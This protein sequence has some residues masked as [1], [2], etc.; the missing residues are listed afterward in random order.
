MTIIKEQKSGHKVTQF[1]PIVL[2]R[3]AGEM[4]SGIAFHVHAAGYRVC[5]TEVAN[6]LAVSRANSF[7]DAVFDGIKNVCGV[8]AE[9]V[10][11]SIPEIKKVWRKG[12]IALLVDPEAAIKEKLHPD[13]LIDGTMTKIGTSTGKGDARL[14][15]GIGPGFYAG[16]D[17]HIVVETNDS[18]GKAGKLIFDGTADEDTEIPVD[19]GGKTVERVLWAP[20]AGTFTAN[21]QIGD[22]LE[23]GQFIG[24]VDN[25]SLTATI[26]GKLR[27]IIRSGTSVPKGAKL[28][29]IDPVNEPGVFFLIRGK[30]W[31]IGEAVVEA[32]SLYLSK[33]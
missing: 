2:I 4:A 33:K 21:M 29:E 25:M 30:I 22:S 18:K 9:R 15:I 23:P 13:V 8:T 16:R 14:V 1:K 17:V 6:P 32:I 3:G 24:K 28:I 20:E 10:T 31:N 5:L 19:T 12:N 26:A 7:S 27:G 11:A